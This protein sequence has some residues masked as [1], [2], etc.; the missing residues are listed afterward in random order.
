MRGHAVQRG[1]LPAFT[2]HS[3]PLLGRR[4]ASPAVPSNTDNPFKQAISRPGLPATAVCT[5]IV[6]HPMQWS[7]ENRQVL[8]WTL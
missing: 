1:A 4:G 6:P 7:S 2:R 5:P 3:P 8:T